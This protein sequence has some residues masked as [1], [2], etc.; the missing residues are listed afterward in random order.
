MESNLRWTSRLSQNVFAVINFVVAIK[1]HKL[2]GCN[3]AGARKFCNA[4]HTTS[5][6]AAVWFGSM[7]STDA[8]GAAHRS[9]CVPR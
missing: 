4:T 1:T 3:C 2:Q 7:S 5:A 8:C 9:K 6:A